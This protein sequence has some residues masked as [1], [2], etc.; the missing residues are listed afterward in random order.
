MGQKQDLPQVGKTPFGTSLW[1]QSEI[2]PLLDRLS[3][4]LPTGMNFDLFGED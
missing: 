3:K 4:S 2:D 1:D